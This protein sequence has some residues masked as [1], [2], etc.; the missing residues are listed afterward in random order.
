MTQKNRVISD[1]NME[2]EIMGDI[3][4]I[5]INLARSI[6]MTRSEKN[7]LLASSKGTLQIGRDREEKMVLTVY[8]PKPA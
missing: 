6:G 2:V 1:R 7:F 3:L 8:R 5:R 4:E